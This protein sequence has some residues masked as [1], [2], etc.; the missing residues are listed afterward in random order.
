[1]FRAILFVPFKSYGI[2]F[3]DSLI[4]GGV[5]PVLM[6]SSG[7]VDKAHSIQG[8]D[9]CIFLNN[10]LS[11]LGIFPDQLSQQGMAPIIP[12]QKLLTDLMECQQIVLPMLERLNYFNLRTTQLFEFY[13]K[14]IANWLG[15]FEAIRP[16][17]LIYS[18]TPHEGF[19]YVGCSL[20]KYFGIRT[21]IA[22]KTMLKDRIMLLSG[23]NTYE[24]FDHTYVA[25][26][27]I[28][29]EGLENYQDFHKI[30]VQNESNSMSINVFVR[31]FKK[32]SKLLRRPSK[33]YRDLLLL[34]EPKFDSVFALSKKKTL[35]LHYRIYGYHESWKAKKLQ[36]Y[37]ASLCRDPDFN[38]RYVF[39][40]LN[41]QPERTTIPLGGKCFWNLIYVLDVLLTSLPKGWKIYVKE[42]PR[43]FSRAILKFSLARNRDFYEKLSAD[44]RVVLMDSNCPAKD[45]IASSKCVAT[46][47]GTAGW[48]AISSGT[49]VMLFGYPWYREC[50]EVFRVDGIV[51]CKMYMNKLNEND[52]SVAS[53]KV[54]AYAAWVENV[55]SYKGGLNSGLPSSFSAGENS[56]LFAN[57]ILDALNSQVEPVSMPDKA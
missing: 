40:P 7:I 22:E 51:D 16:D 39:F 2:E 5:K 43:Q 14:Y 35:L 26:C 44:P 21:I 45:L 36:K 4:Q 48:E 56:R 8:M 23:I 27:E 12:D 37:Y 18:G 1:M 50:P 33:L 47:S 9:D 54:A 15:I 34:F 28:D 6:M 29:N 38:E 20:A 57:S 42:H 25:K 49:P 24:K 3:L 11:C 19:D 17:V 30:I 13:Y 55:A 31:L 32:A 53:E 46:V 41:V 52:V 10:H